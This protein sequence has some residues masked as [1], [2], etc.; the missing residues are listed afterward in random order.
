MKPTF[1]NYQKFIIALLAFIQFT[2]VL[3]FMI[4]SPLGVQVMENLKISTL[5]FGLV[6]SAYA[7]SAGAS[8]ILAAGFA[9]KFDRKNIL[10]FFYGGFVLGTAFCGLATTYKYL[11]AARIVTGLFGGVIASVSFAIIAD[12]FALEVRGRVMGFVMT[13]F[14][15]S[16]VFGLPLSVFISNRWGWQAPFWLIAGISALVG[17]VAFVRVRPITAHLKT[18]GQ[19]NAIKHLVKTATNPNYLPGFLATMLLATG[20]FMLMPF[21]SAFTVHN[22]GLTLE[23][24]P[25][26]YMI[27]GIVSIGAG[28]VLGKLADSAGKYNVFATASVVAIAIILYYTRMEKSP[29][30]LVILINCSLFIP[31]TGRMI[32]AN[33]L[34]SALPDLPDRGAY[35]AISS[36]LQQISGGIAAYCAGLVVVQTTTGRLLGY[37]NL[38]YVVAIAIIA[39]IVMMYRVHIQVLSKNSS[40]IKPN[41]DVTTAPQEVLIEN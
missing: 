24:L 19:K 30:W 27:T 32:S 2:V 14:A 33:A 40:A 3:D 17:I 37:E 28:P 12:L 8:G 35:M 16:Q 4:L 26:I 29:L 1:S 38:G 31:I 9:D 39:T 10:L 41:T 11:L 22:L 6:V 25:L 13:A 23:D 5:D 34:T 7:F 20:G 15:A 21:G 18:A 36:S